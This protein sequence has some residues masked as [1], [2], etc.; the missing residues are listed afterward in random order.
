MDSQLF[1][2]I[3]KQEKTQAQV[4]FDY[5][6]DLQ[7]LKRIVEAFKELYLKE[8]GFP[9]PQEVK[10]QLTDAIKAVF[11][12]WNNH[13]AKVY[14]RINHISD[15]LGTAVNIQEMVF[16]NSGTTSGTGV[17]FTRNPATGENK[18][19]GEYLKNA[20]GEDVV[21]G[22]RTP[23]VIEDLKTEMPEIYSQIHTLAHQLES[24]YHNMQDIEFTIEKGKLFFLQTLSLIHI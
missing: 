18:L 17:L 21:A 19:F 15:Q 23:S 3:L 4:K 22:I 16:G 5:E 2:D 10:I 20:Q 12:S 11:K 6:L 7:A 1:E 14:R 8:L 13:R 24:Y 9:F